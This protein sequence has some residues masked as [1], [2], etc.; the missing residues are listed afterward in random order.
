MKS[1]NTKTVAIIGGGAAGF[2]AAINIAMNAKEKATPPKVTIFESSNQYLKK[3]KISGGGRCNVTHNLFE[4]RS[5]SENYPRGSKELLSPLQKFQAQDTV[6]WFKQQ[7]IELVA[8]V[9][10][11]MF[12]VANT[13]QA[14]IDCYMEATQK[15]NI[16]LRPKQP[17][18]KI[19]I[20]STGTI[21]LHFKDE[22]SFLADSVVIATGSAEGGYDLAESLGHKITERAP[23]LLV[24]KSMT[25]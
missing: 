1:G 11:R 20:G 3:V 7:G 13:S 23:S 6:N 17:V 25:P 24:S 16:E 19:L 5:F 18:K 2:F 12:P 9:D 4:V 10:G 15:Y 22:S 14:I 8:E 21:E